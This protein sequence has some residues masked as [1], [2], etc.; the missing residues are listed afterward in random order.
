M[1][2]REVYQKDPSLRKLVNEGVA[3]VN[4]DKT[5]LA[6]AVLRY[7]LETFVCDG[8]YEKGL[9]QILSTYIANIGAPQQPAVW[10][11]GFFGSGKSHLVK[12]LRS[13]WVNTSFSDGATARGI[14]N[15][16]ESIKDHLKE[17]STQGKRHGG[18]H[19]ASGT[20]GSGASGSV[21]LALL[22]I[23]FKS[24]DLPEQYHLARFVMW[25]MKEGILDQVRSHVEKDG[26]TWEEELSN[27]YV[28]E[29]LQQALIAIKPHSFS[30]PEI[31][32][33]TLLN[34]YPNVQDVSNDEMVDAI[35][36]ALKVEGKLPLTL[37]V[38]DEVQQF[39][40]ENPDRSRDV[41]E[42]V[43]ACCKK[44]GGK[45][46]FIG[47]GQTAITGTPNLK[48][49]EGR[50]TLRIELSDADVE[51][52]VRKVILAKKADAITPIEQVMQTNLGE[53]SRQLIGTTIAHRQDDIP[54]FPHDYPMLPIRRRFWENTLR[55]LDETGTDSQLRNQLSMIH[56]V[57][58]TNLDKTL[59][60][61]IPAD[62]LYFDS[63]V[64][65]QQ[66]RKLP[67]K[68]Y[69]KTMSWIEGSPEE[70]LMARACGLV[71]LINK[72]SGNNREI[73]IRATVDTLADLLVEDLNEGS[74]GLRSTLPALL[75]K[76]ELLMR[77][78]DEYRIQTEESSAWID[79]FQSQKSILANQPTRV[80]TER[81]DR[82]RL[83]FGDLVGKI[84]LTQGNSKQ[85]REAYPLFSAQLP[86]D[87]DKKIYIWVRDGWKTD[88]N[89]VRADA[90][91]AGNQSPTIY[92][93]IPKRSADDLR[94]Y[95]IEYKAAIA[96]LGSRD[97]PNTPE[98]IEAKAAMETTK[99]TA[100]GKIKELLEETFSGARVFQSG[101]NEIIANHLQGMVQEAARN[102]GQRLFPQF[103]VADQKDWD[104]VYE[105]AKKGSPDALKAI[106]DEGEPAKNQVCK[107]IL[108]FI[109]G[110]KQGA[111]IREHFEA[112]P[113][114]W[115][116]DAIDGALQVLLVGGVIK[117][118]DD[119]GRAIDPKE[120]ERRAMGKSVFKVES[121]TVSTP[122]RIQI[123]KVFQKANIVVTAGQESDGVK[124][125]LEFIQA[126]AEQAGGDGPKPEKPDVSF[127]HEIRL[128]SGNEQLI[129]I[130]NLKDTL[131][132]NIDTWTATA[133]KITK[134][135]P[136]WG[137]LLE[138]AQSAEGTKIA[139]EVKPQIEVITHQRRL[140]DEPDL[141]Q[142]LITTLEQALRSELV[143]LAKR[144]DTDFS[145]EL[146]NL[147]QDASWQEIEPEVRE[148]II[149]TCGIVRMDPLSIATIEDLIKTLKRNPISSWN[150]KIDAL[151]KRF[152]KAREMAAKEL[153]P[154]TQ[155]I[156][157][158]KRTLKSAEDVEDWIEEV[159]G[160]LS[161]SIPKGPIILR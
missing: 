4:D 63:A 21:R 17:L 101:G 145:E 2:N 80:D 84:T 139:S 66:T 82:I 96:T 92:V 48:K 42:V 15:L 102:S 118:Q 7:E 64:T 12:M 116:G 115:S 29:G 104:K 30:T 33:E 65:L 9:D 75:N 81:E 99:Q 159:S 124:P 108:S 58:Q 131:L 134:K 147:E 60:F 57:I 76:C 129:T 161:E 37:V 103:S 98:G 5:E 47:T 136:L 52:V 133:D 67:R 6:L 13:L 16:P 86:T 152:S 45:L 72:L 109:A 117:A 22:R 44:I 71:F 156:T 155:T 73:G 144:Y 119:H 141:I 53:I 146:Q 56:K 61:V 158:P 121:T 49:I 137:R 87:H 23:V 79:E 120:L 83:M 68:V 55:V 135:W 160:L 32:V 59:G 43:S 113:Y 88:E 150:D 51:T 110:G 125:F 148:E 97:V 85:N 39:I 154:K 77:V 132:T 36:S 114:G 18:V 10:V 153:E 50:F 127:I 138:I 107:Q 31:C 93:Y 105:R 34:Q 140:L 69:E 149:T 35:E 11:S 27:F 142:P 89:S 122:Q 1:I 74:S 62:Y 25:M 112:P 19:A 40:G 14:A 54:F 157:L 46:L 111:L 8:Q 151:R 95:L 143:A 38:L 123:R 70:Q 100:E 41:D 94:H 3:Y 90:R 130:Y 26:Y 20:L 24:V 28:A 78:G 128:T 126:L 106:G 91:Q